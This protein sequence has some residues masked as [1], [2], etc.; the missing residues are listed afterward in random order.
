MNRIKVWVYVVAVVAVAFVT[1]RVHTQRLR[2]A[3]SSDLDARLAAASGHV[4]ASTRA[5]ARE[6]S[7]AA[8]LAARDP[9]L[10]AALHAAPRPAA[11]L[12]R[13][14]K[15]LRPPAP[16][17]APANGDAQET[18]LREA[19]RAALATAERT[20]G[21]DLPEGTVV[22]AANREWLARKGKSGEGEGEVV[23]LLRGAVG[24]KSQRG[25]VRLNGIVYYAASAPAGD[26]AGLVV[27]API[28]DT[29]VRSLA[30]TTAVLVTLS[31]PEVKPV[32]TA[33]A[34][35]QA[36]AG[37]NRGAGIPV[38]VGQIGKAPFALGPVKL[39]ALPV[40]FASA[41][42]FRARAVALDGLKGGFLVAAVPAAPVLGA[43]AQIHWEL[44]VGLAVALLAG[45]LLGFLVRP[46]EAAAALPEELV[47]A[48]SRIE[49]GDFGA[50]VPP[51][52]GKFGVVGTALNRAAELA[53]PAAAAESARASVSG[54]FYARG[55]APQ[56]SEAAEPPA[57]PPEPE[58]E[59][60][61]GPEPTPAPAPA[62]VQSA[63]RAAP[64]A[65][66]AEADEETHFQQVFQ[67]FLRTRATCGE[68][69]EGLTYDR[70]RLKLDGNK[71]A[72]VSKYGCRTVKFQVYVKDG[73][74]A[75]KATPVK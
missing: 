63:A 3:A 8:A 60:P 42:A 36:F 53:G 26:A 65:A 45:I 27:L 43:I 22:T 40:P 74:A 56:P 51:L 61:E 17:P 57:P 29:W 5:V 16:A 18:A 58:Q 30:A 62:V 4:L 46:S 12:P 70:F 71:A 10:L 11:P 35:A 34:D 32:S 14:A 15:K 28:D 9:Q 39:G 31:A 37:W 41:P 47:S 73:K 20:M 55:A 64:P 13:K 23:P 52:A 19:A 49:R 69:S 44:V 54:E 66:A 59:H 25:Y 24:G 33:G 21:F 38:D 7:A 72:L 75:L 2:A 1:L 48:A 67:E 6:A 50:R 68:P